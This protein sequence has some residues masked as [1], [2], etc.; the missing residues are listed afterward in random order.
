MGHSE[1]MTA[2]T[3]AEAEVA[4]RKALLNTLIGYPRRIH[5]DAEALNDTAWEYLRAANH[6]H[7]VVAEVLREAAH[8]LTA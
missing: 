7:A 6:A 3:M 2:D 1:S 8:E 5:F 4:L